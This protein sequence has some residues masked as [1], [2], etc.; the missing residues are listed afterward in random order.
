MIIQLEELL[1]VKTKLGDGYALLFESGEHDNYW[2]VILDS[3]ALVTFPQDQ[4]LVSS[5]YT[6][7]RNVSHKRMRKV[8][9]DVRRK[10]RS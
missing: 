7:G 10:F 4:L 9:K 1:P 3:G 8:I 5:S 6:Y 2:T